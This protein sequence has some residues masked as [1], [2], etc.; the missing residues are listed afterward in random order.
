MFNFCS[1]SS[2]SSGNCLLVCSDNCN[3]LVDVGISMK[4]INTELEKINL[5]LND[6]NA[7]LVTHEHIDHCKALSTINRKYN[8]PL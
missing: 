5:T 4:K 2:S 6:I 7:I 1:L 8:I 3:I